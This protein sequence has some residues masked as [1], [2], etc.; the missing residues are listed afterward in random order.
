V[1]QRNHRASKIPWLLLLIFV[2]SDW[3]LFLTYLN[4]FGIKGFVVGVVV[5]V[6]KVRQ[7]Q[8]RFGYEPLK[9]GV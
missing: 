7:H 8:G 2:I 9:S 5:V 6:R 1:R 3:V 4:L